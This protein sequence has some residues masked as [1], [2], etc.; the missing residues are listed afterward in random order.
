M[1]LHMGG[2]ERERGRDGGREKR[3]KG[4]EAR[5]HDDFD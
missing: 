2:G 3:K 4:R 1:I 5:D